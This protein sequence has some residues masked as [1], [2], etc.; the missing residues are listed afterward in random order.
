MTA[1]ID[2]PILPTPRLPAYPPVVVRRLP[3][4]PDTEPSASPA[5]APAAASPV[6]STADP[7]GLPA[8]APPPAP[9]PTRPAVPGNPRVEIE[10]VLRLLM[11]MLDGRR[12]ATQAGG[13]IGAMPLR[14]LVA[15][16]TRLKPAGRRTGSASRHGPPGLR[17]FRMSHPAENVTEVSARWADRGRFRALAA[18]FEWRADRWTC[19]VLR[20][21]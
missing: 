12:P 6:E 11:E 4:E 13:R 15:A 19:T 2:V 20:L 8:A 3:L 17:S 14:Y 9:R 10:R 5:S 21:G 7:A 18:R 16:R 1:T